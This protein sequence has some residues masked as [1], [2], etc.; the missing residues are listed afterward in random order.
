MLSSLTSREREV[1]PFLVMG[2]TNKQIGVKLFLSDSTIKAHIE[3]ILSKL[4]VRNRIQAAAVAAYFLSITPEEIV[5]TA[6]R[7]KKDY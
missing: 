2:Y 1:L 4:Q 7:P 3:K 6:G 5:R